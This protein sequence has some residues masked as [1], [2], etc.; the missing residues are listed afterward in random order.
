MRCLLWLLVNE[1]DWQTATVE[2]VPATHLVSF[3]TDRR[4]SESAY[5]ADS[6]LMTCHCCWLGGD[7]RLR[8]VSNGLTD[9]AASWP[10]TLPETPTV[11]TELYADHIHIDSH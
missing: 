5:A 9:R 3:V 10:D 8:A 11:V 2:Q 1:N 4:S 7:I 6:K